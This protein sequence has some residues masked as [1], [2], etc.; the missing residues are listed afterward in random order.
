MGEE[1]AGASASTYSCLRHYC[2][3]SRVRV[4]C[5]GDKGAVGLVW[6]WNCALDSSETTRTWILTKSGSASRSCVAAAVVDVSTA[7]E[8]LQVGAGVRIGD[9]L[10]FVEVLVCHLENVASPV[11]WVE[12]SAAEDFVGPL[13]L[14]LQAERAPRHPH[15]QPP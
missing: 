1:G 5:K 3:I 2:R 7:V 6:T 13:Q 10:G 15:P 12:V 14:S 4:P 11:S 9:L 8:I